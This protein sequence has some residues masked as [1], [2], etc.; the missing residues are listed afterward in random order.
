MIFKEVSSR[1]GS[2]RYNEPIYSG[3]FFSVVLIRSFQDI[4]SSR[5]ILGI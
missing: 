4:F 2:A 3:N 1:Y 5:V